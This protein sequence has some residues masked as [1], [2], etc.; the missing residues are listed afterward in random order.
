R[1]VSIHRH[2]AEAAASLHRRDGF[3]KQFGLL[4]WLRYVIDAESGSRGTIRSFTS[5]ARI[6]TDWLSEVASIESTL[7]LR[8]PRLRTATADVAGFLSPSLVNFGHGSSDGEDSD[9]PAPVA[10]AYDIL[11]KWAARGEDPADHAI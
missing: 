8:F 7:G 2:P 4:L 3:E 5:F 9:L 11:E 10:Q 1:T 6:M